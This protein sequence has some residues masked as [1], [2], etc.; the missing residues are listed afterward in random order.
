MFEP[1]SNP[2]YTQLSE[3]AKDLIVGWARN[4]WYETSSEELTQNEN[5]GLI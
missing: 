4:D 2:G 3:D 5:A 1:E